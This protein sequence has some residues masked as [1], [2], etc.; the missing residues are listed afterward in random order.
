MRLSNRSSLSLAGMVLAAALVSGV[1]ASAT[2]WI[3]EAQ[4]IGVEDNGVFGVEEC[5]LPNR[6]LRVRSRWI[7]TSGPEWPWGPWWSWP[8][9]TVVTTDANGEFSQSQY[10]LNPDLARDIEIQKQESV[11]PNAWYTI[12][13][14]ENVNGMAPDFT[15]G[16]DDR[17]FD[18]GAIEIPATCEDVFVPADTDD[19][20][21]RSGKG[22]K[23]DKGSLFDREPVAQAMP[24]GLDPFG[25]R[26]IDLVFSSV[27][28]RHRDLQPN[29]PPQR[30]TWE[31]VVRNAGTS[32]YSG[33][34]SCLAEASV[35]FTR[36]DPNDGST[37]E[38]TY[39]NTS[40]NCDVQ[41]PLAPGASAIVTE[42]GNLWEIS[43]GADQ[44]DVFFEVD[45]HGQIWESDESNN[46]AVGC[47]EPAT[48]T[49]QL[50]PCQ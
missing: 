3:I 46:T 26:G 7:S 37:D 4:L 44:V 16:W 36:T 24:C 40:G 30:V 6:D 47:Y 42:D 50:G 18:L 8:A 11:W 29:A 20:D 45:P 14:I 39:C 19:D 15:A 23:S 35:T 31:V 10:M 41:G 21:D 9:N 32:S 49:F 2:D 22:D 13:I 25:N 27:T 38:R 34:E 12:A 43:E 17:G 28:V 33:T 1:P 48:E 5:V